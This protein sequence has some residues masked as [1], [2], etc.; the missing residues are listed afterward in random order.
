MVQMGVTGLCRTL[1]GSDGRDR[2]MSH[3]VW[4]RWAWQVYVAR[5]M[6]QMGVTG[7]CRTLYG[8]D[9]RDR[10][11][12]HVFRMSSWTFNGGGKI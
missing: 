11:M 8:S 5:C 7:L 9:G 3:V 1:Y 10:F 2:F 4:F 12:S 6:V